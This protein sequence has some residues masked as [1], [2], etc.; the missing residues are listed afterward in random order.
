MFTNTGF[1]FNEKEK[2]I[3]SIN[4]YNEDYYEDYY[5]E[6]KICNRQTIIDYTMFIIC[7][8]IYIFIIY[9]VY[10]IYHYS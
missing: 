1:C 4:Y 2:D 10:F 5:E 9:V 7:V 8:N 3:E 6:N